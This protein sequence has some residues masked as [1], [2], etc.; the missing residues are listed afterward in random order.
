MPTTMMNC[1]AHHSSQKFRQTDDFRRDPA[2][3]IP[4]DPKATLLEYLIAMEIKAIAA[5]K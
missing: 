4:C 3:L 1:N 2:C 5:T